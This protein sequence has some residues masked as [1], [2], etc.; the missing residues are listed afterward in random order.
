MK[1]SVIFKKSLIFKNTYFSKIRIFQE[2]HEKT[3]KNVYN[4]H[5]KNPVI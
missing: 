4:K 5:L 3:R 2:T 1:K